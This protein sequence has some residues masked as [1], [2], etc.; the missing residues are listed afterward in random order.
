MCGVCKVCV[1]S[2][3][4]G[5][6][7]RSKELAHLLSLERF[8]SSL[9]PL[10]TLFFLSMMR[11]AYHRE[12][13]GHVLH[14]HDRQRAARRAERGKGNPAELACMQTFAF[15]SPPLLKP[16]QPYGQ[17][18]EI[19][20]VCVLQHSGIRP[21]AIGCSW[22]SIHTTPNCRTRPRRTALHWRGSIKSATTFLPS[23]LLCCM[24]RTIW[25]PVLCKASRSPLHGVIV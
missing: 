6:N 24:S 12:V 2:G 16:L 8:L 3:R 18:R 21:S 19:P 23:F 25:Q 17:T 20:L 15:L 7:C 22:R 9:I 1:W 5:G 4:S 14:G 13:Y 10:F 11:Q